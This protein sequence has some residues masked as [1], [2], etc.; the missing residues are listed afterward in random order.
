MALCQVTIKQ[1]LKEDKICS[2]EVQVSELALCSPC[3]PKV[4][5]LHHFMVTAVKAALD[6]DIPHHSS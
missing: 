5:D 1:I 3:C 6:L 4:L 2:P